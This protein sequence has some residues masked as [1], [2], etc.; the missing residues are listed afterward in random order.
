MECS[1]LLI[2]GNRLE[3]LAQLLAGI[4]EGGSKDPFAPRVILTDGPEM[5]S[6]LLLQLAKHSKAGAVAGLK[7]LSW[8]EGMRYLWHDPGKELSYLQLY[9]FIYEALRKSEEATVKQ[10]IEM[11]RLSDLARELTDLFVRYGYYGEHLPLDSGWQ[12]DLWKKLFLEGFSRSPW[13]LLEEP[14]QVSASVYV[15]GASHFAPSVWR[16]LFK[17]PD[18][19][20]FHFSPC[21]S[22]WADARSDLERRRLLQFGKKKKVSEREL[23]ELEEYLLDAQPL[24]GSWG[25]VGRCSLEL[26]EKFDFDLEEIYDPL[27]TSCNLLGSVQKD[28]LFH[29]KSENKPVDNSIQ[30]HQTGASKLREVQVLR[31]EMVRAHEKGIPFSEMLILAPDISLYA[32]LIEMVF[33]DPEFLIPCHISGVDL[34]SQNGVWQG[35]KRLID[36]ALSYWDVDS[37]LLLFENGPFREKRGWDLQRLDQIRSFLQE[38]HIRWGESKEFKQTR[39]SSFLTTFET[40]ERGSWMDGIERMLN[41]LIYLFPEKEDLGSIRT[42]RGLNLTQADEL[43]ELLELFFQLKT[44]LAPLKN[45]LKRADEWGEILKNLFDAYFPSDAR[46]CL[47]EI[48]GSLKKAGETIQEEIPFSAFLHLFERKQTG[49]IGSTL[50]HAARFAPFEAGAI[51][52]CRALFLLGFDEESFPRKKASSSLDLLHSSKEAPPLMSDEDRYLFLQAV[53]CPRDFLNISYSHI[54]PD[55]GKEIGPSILVRE[56][57]DYVGNIKPILHPSS[58]WHQRCYLDPSCRPRAPA[59]IR[60]LKAFHEKKEPLCCFPV[61]SKMPELYREQEGFVNLGSASQRKIDPNER[62]HCTSCKAS[63]DDRFYAGVANPNSQNLPARGIKVPE[64]DLVLR[65]RD[66]K[67]CFSSPWKFYLE[68]KLNIYFEEFEEEDWSDFEMSPL[69]RSQLLK[70]GL[71]SSIEPVLDRLEKK[72]LLPAGL[73]GKVAS[74]SA[75]R[76]FEEWKGHL[77]SWDSSGSLKELIIQ[78]GT[79]QIPFGEKTVHLIGMVRHVS[80]KGAIHFG[81]DSFS[82]LLKNWPEHLA[83]LTALQSNE[84]FCIRSGKLKLV[85]DPKAA[86]KEC[87]KLYLLGLETPLPIV[88]EWVD[89]LVRKGDAADLEKKINSS[90]A[91]KDE[92]Y[93]WVLERS[94]PMIAKDLI[95]TWRASLQESLKD[96]LTLYPVRAKKH[97]EI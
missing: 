59:E 30:L 6:W 44:D 97:A 92:I 77:D 70:E 57:L 42:V 13:Q 21:L 64:A 72:H 22:Y 37:V 94:A 84:I 45:D 79:I 67:K 73:F 63:E 81:E 52:P 96:L 36:L 5:K 34:L 86:L 68:K 87:I 12:S 28:L 38:A 9:L 39:L 89:A 4:L 35:F 41:S 3:M 95:H 1:A 65:L 82:S 58:L 33:S 93:T 48:F 75:C 16:A 74:L 43:E 10:Y 54:S 15:F 14:M 69:Q 17:L 20:I 71:S 88:S 56:L 31:G 26:F 2:L 83:A 19:H 7:I 23:D 47:D 49:S 85:P 32:P 91:D 80:S 24:L 46:G 51:T 55:D 8:Q 25:K 90:R 76:I 50:L 18:V 66:L 60:A 40:S 53:C 62:D 11:A 29:R 27:E 61:S 78:E